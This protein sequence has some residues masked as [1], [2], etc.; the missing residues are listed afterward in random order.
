MQLPLNYRH[1][2]TSGF[3]LVE[4][5]VV[6]TVISILAA[7]AIPIYQSYIKKA[8]DSSCLS[9]M[10][11]Y[12]V[13]IVSEKISENPT[14]A[15]IP[16]VSELTHCKE[17]TERPSNVVTLTALVSITAKAKSGTESVIICDINRAA[18]C[19]L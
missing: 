9:E 13:K 14:L 8:N 15:N 10:K 4:L 19:Y 5:M 11:S 17:V 3:T 2:H 7:T 16:L 12:A 18:S 1:K 6:I